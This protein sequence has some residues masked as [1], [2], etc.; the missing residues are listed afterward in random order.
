M[1]LFVSC[2]DIGGVLLD[3]HGGELM[4]KK[5]SVETIA[6]AKELF[7]KYRSIKEVSEIIGIHQS[8]IEHW[9][10]RDMWVGFSRNQK[11][12]QKI[13]RCC[14]LRPVPKNN[15]WLCDECFKGTTPG[16]FDETEYEHKVYVS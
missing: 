6:K 4:N 5:H 11:K 12:N 9:K 8:T 3:E 13:C 7:L 16:C 10:K 2:S 14:G 15:H 1:A